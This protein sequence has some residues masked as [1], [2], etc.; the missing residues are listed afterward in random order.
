ML[1]RGSVE[2]SIPL[3]ARTLETSEQ[4]VTLTPRLEIGCIGC[5]FIADIHLG[6]LVAH[7]AARLRG[8]ADL[9]PA[10]AGDF[11]KRFGADYAFTDPHRLL[12]DP[13]IDAVLICTHPDSHAEL[14]LAAARAGKHI[15]L[16]KPMARTSE[17]C[18][19]ILDACREHNVRVAIDLKFRHTEAVRAVK[20]HID[21]PI[22]ISGQSSMNPFPDGHDH[23]DSA[24]GGGIVAD[25]GT[26]LFDLACHFAGAE[27][28]RVFARGN[29]MPSRTRVEYDAVVGTLEFPTG[30][31]ASFLISDCGEWA[32]SSK[33]FFQVSDGVRQAVINNHCRTALIEEG[34]RT[35]DDSQTP[36]HAIGTREAL[37][38][39]LS[40]IREQRDPLVGGMDG[41]RAA[42]LVEAVTKSLR[43]GQPVPIHL[44]V[45]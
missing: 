2:L 42:A 26:H 16:E 24:K 45:R 7:P 40:S 9:R 44:P 15:F 22:L 20:A 19:E 3:P 43:S 25:L 4:I 5:G 38:D 23:L 29:R 28:V 36:A 34:D 39:F 13:A 27:P 33:W 30:A 41:L 8:V 11:Q 10:A 35:V 1:T 6:N 21:R 31:I 32:Y 12:D 17:E 18:R 37:D 14:A